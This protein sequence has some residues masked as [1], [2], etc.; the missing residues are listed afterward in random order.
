MNKCEILLEQYESTH[1][2]HHEA[3]T[4]YFQWHAT[5]NEAMERGEITTDNIER[6]VLV[7]P[8]NIACSRCRP[9]FDALIA[10]YTVENL[11]LAQRS[12]RHLAGANAANIPTSTSSRPVWLPTRTLIILCISIISILILVLVLTHSP[13]GGK[14]VNEIDSPCQ[15]DEILST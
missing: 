10:D 7:Y 9:F 12:V 15:D 2:K 5:V 11:I 4:A 3:E 14:I 13:S 8:S 6:P 1:N